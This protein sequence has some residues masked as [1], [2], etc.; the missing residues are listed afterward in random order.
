MLVAGCVV[1][2]LAALRL[3]RALPPH[4]NGI[5][6]ESRPRPSTDAVASR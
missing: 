1:L 2:A 4:A 5:V 3:E 6:S